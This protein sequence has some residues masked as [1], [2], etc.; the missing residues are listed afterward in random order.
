MN[1]PRTHKG[2]TLIDVLLGA[3][4]FSIVMSIF[5]ATVATSIGA[6]R[7]IILKHQATNLAREGIEAMEFV[8]NTDNLNGLS[9]GQFVQ[10]R[11]PTDLFWKKK[12][13]QVTFSKLEHKGGKVCLALDKTLDT[14]PW[15]FI[16]TPCGGKGT[17]L[18]LFSSD[19]IHFYAAKGGGEET[20][21]SQII[22]L[23][24]ITGTLSGI[25]TTPLTDDGSLLN[26]EGIIKVTSTITWK[27]GNQDKE[28]SLTKLLTHWQ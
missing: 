13:S 18:S 2:F 16:E 10:G 24:N 14:P 6:S 12:G 26:N 20:P 1:K 4:V 8:R 28:I 22:T 9:W 23:E 11:Y 7:N 15:R 3:A 21:F 19:D 17:K 25:A 5:I 27:Q